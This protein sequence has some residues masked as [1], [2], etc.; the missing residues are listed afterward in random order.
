VE[1]HKICSE[2]NLAETAFAVP[3]QDD[4]SVYNL[5]WFTPDNEEKLCG[6]A[7]LATTHV[8][9]SLAAAQGVKSFTYNSLSGPLKAGKTEDELFEL[10]F[11]ADDVKEVEGEERLKIEKAALASIRGQG[12]V[13]TIF[14]GNFDVIIEVV[15]DGDVNLADLDVIH[16]ELVSLGTVHP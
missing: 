1:S 11:P 13:K 6:H 7:T 14:R 5:K 10:D 3:N 9:S 12:R 4:P 2:F 16:N 15:M 8:L